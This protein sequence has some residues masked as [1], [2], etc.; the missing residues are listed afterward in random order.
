[1]ASATARG[2][3][4]LRLSACSLDR[5]T[6]R[7]VGAALEMFRSLVPTGPGPWGFRRDPGENGDSAMYDPQT[8]Q[9]IILLVALGFFLTLMMGLFYGLF[10]LARIRS[11]AVRINQRLDEL[12][13]RAD[14]DSATAE[15]RT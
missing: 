14:R 13:A 10:L 15:R 8:I 11:Q 4:L 5:R 3:L 7:D 6:G 12:L 9:L 1:M 2:W